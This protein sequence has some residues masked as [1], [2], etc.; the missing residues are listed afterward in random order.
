MKISKENA[1]FGKPIPNVL[2]EFINYHECRENNLFAA[3][4]TELYPFVGSEAYVNVMD[5]K[6]DCPIDNNHKYGLYNYRLSDV[7]Q[8]DLID[9]LES[10]LKGSAYVKLDE[11]DVSSINDYVFPSRCWAK[12]SWAMKKQGSDERGELLHKTIS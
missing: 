5:N 4:Y 3:Q 12:K 10:D 9:C 8:K 2:G 1:F 6:F 7:E 11:W